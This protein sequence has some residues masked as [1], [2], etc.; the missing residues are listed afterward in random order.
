MDLYNWSLKVLILKLTPA[1]VMIGWRY[2]MKP[3][4]KG[5]VGA[6]FLNPSPALAKI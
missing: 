1:V 4:V 3:T 5:S 6:Q 2:L